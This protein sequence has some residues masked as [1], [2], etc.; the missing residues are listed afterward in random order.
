MTEFDTDT[1]WLPADAGPEFD[2]LEHFDALPDGNTPLVVTPRGGA[3]EV[4]RSCYQVDTEHATYLVDCGLR[5]GSGETFPDFRGL[6]L[7]GV[8]AVF[9]THAHIDHCGGLPVLEANGLLDDDAPILATPP[10]IALAK[11]LLEDSLHIH[12][13]E[14]QRSGTEQRFD[15][16]H[17]DAVFERFEPVDYGGGRVEPFA[18]TPDEEPLVFQYGNAGHLLGSAWLML[19]TGG[20][21]VVFSGDIG[22]RATHLPDVQSPPGADVLLTESTYGSQHSHTSMHDARSGLFAAVAQAVEN[23]QP[24]LIPT[25]AVGRAQLLQLLFKER[26]TS[27]P[28]DIGSRVQLVVDGMAQDA[29]EIYH[30]YV[31]DDT[32]MDES[33]VNRAK[34]SG[35]DRPFLP[36]GAGFPRND[37]ERRELLT[38]TDPLSGGTVPVVIA[39]SGMLTGGHSPR[40]LVE[41]AARFEDAKVFLTGYQSKGTTG[42]TLQNYLD[43]GEDEVTITTD[44]TPFGTDWPSSDS[45]AWTRVET[46]DGFERTTRATV[47]TEWIETVDGLSAHAAQSGL[48]KFARAV[49]P[50]TVA[51]VHGPDYAQD[52]LARHF[53]KNLD[54]AKQVTRSRLLTPIPVS[55]DIELDTPTLTPEQ[56]ERGPDRLRNQVKTLHTEVASLNEELAALRHDEGTWSESALRRLVREEIREAIDTD[57]DT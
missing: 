43:A 14:T 11:L 45:V 31:L 9:L 30:E 6:S 39:P 49:E 33:I 28:G 44:A 7:E 16:Q 25:F 15:R 35:Q 13:R 20:Y 23:R 37:E 8:D 53:G 18:P 57:G 47:P 42:R 48:L 50:S 17:V 26:F 38:D 41:F 22:G 54:S 5:Q 2:P 34:N 27:H 55:R 24:V 56:F 10:T 40:Y 3:R 12:R 36:D 21:R 52:H 4:G 46:D 1:P 51:M 19:Q 29:T 32:Y